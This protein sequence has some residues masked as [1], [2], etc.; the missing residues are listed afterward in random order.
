MAA[1]TAMTSASCMC[2]RTPPSGGPVYMK[3]MLSPFC[4]NGVE[5]E[6]SSR[7]ILRRRRQDNQWWRSWLDRCLP[8]HLFICCV[9]RQKRYTMSKNLRGICCRT[10]AA[11]RFQQ[12]VKCTRNVAA[13]EAQLYR[14]IFNHRNRRITRYLESQ[15]LGLLKS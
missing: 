12:R 14:D 4:S 1:S 7:D 3:G 15:I 8:Q 13:S 11:P 5:I 9:I 2:N 6:H 10:S